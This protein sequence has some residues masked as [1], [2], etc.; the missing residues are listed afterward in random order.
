M[1]YGYLVAFLMVVAIAA[2]TYW[3]GRKDGSASVQVQ[4][5]QS[6]IALRDAAEADRKAQQ[7]KAAALSKRYESRIATQATVTKEIRSQLEIALAKKPLP[8]ACVVDDSLLQLVNAALAG[9]SPAAGELPS[10]AGTAAAAKDG[11]R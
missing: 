3:Q 1:I 5:D 11:P 10:G 7:Q 4:W 9:K 2:S 8:A 6:V